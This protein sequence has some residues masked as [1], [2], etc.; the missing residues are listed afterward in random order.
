MVNR[1]T[2]CVA[3]KGWNIEHQA[4]AYIQKCQDGSGPT[5]KRWITLTSLF[6]RRRR[7]NYLENLQAVIYATSLTVVFC[8]YRGGFSVMILKYHLQD[9]KWFGHLETTSK[10]V[11]LRKVLQML[12]CVFSKMS[13]TVWIEKF[14]IL[15]TLLQVNAFLHVSSQLLG[16]FGNWKYKL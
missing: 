1:C 13:L 4:Y 16:V 5:C 10:F 14:Y 11:L 12:N 2:L 3:A 7:K 8:V 6:I 15:V 9:W